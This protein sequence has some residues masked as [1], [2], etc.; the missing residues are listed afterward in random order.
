M[1]YRFTNAD[2]SAVVRE[3]DG[4]FIPATHP[5]WTQQYLPWVAAG[6]ATLP[7]VSP[8][9]PLPNS[10]LVTFPDITLAQLATMA[11]ANY[12]GQS[13]RLTDPAGSTVGSEITSNGT[14]WKYLSD[15][16]PVVY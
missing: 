11:P 2:G 10:S 1:A 12:K 3:E 9:A 6:N 16:S 8:A 13:Y 14:I 5:L 7:F 4:I 15:S